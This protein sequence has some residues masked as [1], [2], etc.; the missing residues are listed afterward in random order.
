MKDAC[1]VETETESTYARG[2]TPQDIDMKDPK[3]DVEVLDTTLRDGAQTSGVSFTLQEKLSITKKL[4]ELGVSYVEGG[5]PGS[6]PKDVSYFKEAKRLPLENTEVVAFGSTKR[7]GVSCKNDSNL[8]SLLESEVRTAVIFG[9][10]WTL[11]VKEVLKISPEENLDCVRETIEHLRDHGIETIFD[12]E[13]F[14]DGYK[15][16]KEYALSVLKAAEKGGAKVLVLA[17]TN[18]GTLCHEL[19]DIVRDV[20]KSVT[21]P[22]GIHAHNDSGLA[23]ANTLM[24]V[25]EGVKHV[26]V[27]ANGL[28]ERCGNADLMQVVPALELKLRLKALKGPD[29]SRLKLLVGFSKYIYDILN[30]P[31]DPYQPYVGSKAF[32]HKGGVHVDAVLKTRSSYEHIDPALVGNRRELLVSELAGRAAVMNEALKLGMELEKQS[33]TVSKTLE[34]VK[35]LES[36]GNLL[37]SADATIHM[38]LYRNLGI[39][40]SFFEVP[41]WMVMSRKHESLQTEGQV[42]VRSGGDVLY[43]RAEGVGPVHAVDLSLRKALL[44]RFPTL[45]DVVLSNYKVTVVEGVKGTASFVRVLIEFSDG[46]KRWATTYTSDNILEA[47]AQALI[48][49]YNYKLLSD[50]LNHGEKGRPGVGI[51][52]P[53][54]DQSSKHEEMGRTERV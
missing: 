42:V 24:A 32:A 43:A 51:L 20:K 25:M 47:S 48:E 11:H 31:P 52:T 37:E 22:L 12:A 2:W 13:H 15:S 39:K 14:F 46:N 49:G 38:I 26:Q 36:R 8:R 53:E 40:T 35:A 33:E 17:D 30:M 27:T 19:V 5:W 10:S 21:K 16:D 4:D 29:E 41:H 45:G 54:H 3:V 50:S 1:C 18:G 44:T 34:E 28:G 7:S 6:N 23:V 9:K